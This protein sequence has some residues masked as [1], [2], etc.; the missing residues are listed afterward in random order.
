MLDQETE[1]ARG[2]VQGVA[3][4]ARAAIAQAGASAMSQAQAADADLSGIRRS[5]QSADRPDLRSY[6]S[7]FGGIVDAPQSRIATPPSGTS[8]S[9]STGSHARAQ[10]SGP[11]VSRERVARPAINGPG[12]GTD[13]VGD[14]T[15]IG[16]TIVPIVVGS[17]AGS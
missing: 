11:S 6:L 2:A 4:S 17:S 7:R 3:S 12:T 9:S 16:T 14:T 5:Q 15:T 8:S 13:T 10:I 1:P